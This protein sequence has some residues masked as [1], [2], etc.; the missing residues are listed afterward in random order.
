MSGRAFAHF[1]VANDIG[2]NLK[3]ARMKPAER[4]AYVAGV[5]SIAAQAEM[6][7]TLLI[8]RA[9]ADERD[10]ARQADVPVT[11]ARAALK[12][13]RTLGVLERDADGIEWVHDFGVHN[14]QPRRDETAAER[15][16]RY[17][18]KQRASRDAPRDV[19]PPSRRDARD[20]HA[21][22]THRD[23]RNGHGGVTSRKEVEVE[24]EVEAAAARAPAADHAE[25]RLRRLA[26]DVGLACPSSAVIDE[27]LAKYSDRDTTAA[28][29]DLERWAQRERLHSLVGAW[30]QALER[31][32]RRKLN[33][34]AEM[35]ESSFARAAMDRLEREQPDEDAGL[36][37]EQ[38]D[39]LAVVGAH[40]VELNR[41]AAS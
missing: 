1:M 40:A 26:S 16:Q 11:V 8:G 2:R 7:G 21:T 12:Q 14:P 27:L 24:V 31:A 36:T 34:A 15:A 6:R 10:V 28:L 39:T 4:W 30:Q 18:D 41:R 35:A 20:D 33:G 23:E 3:L 19:T 9:P 29:D 38:R 5:L 22:V 37:G 25:S 17:R 13:L 32:D